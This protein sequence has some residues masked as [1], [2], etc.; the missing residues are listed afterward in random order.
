MD[1]SISVVFIAATVL[2][3]ALTCSTKC[4]IESFYPEEESID[5][6]VS[7]CATPEQLTK[8][9]NTIHVVI[10]TILLYSLSTV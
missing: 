5:P 4:T 6:F 7:T 2:L 9:V 1:I 8:K 10:P 3:L